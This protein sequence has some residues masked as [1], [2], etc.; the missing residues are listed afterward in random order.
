MAPLRTFKEFKALVEDEWKGT[1]R[2]GVNTNYISIK[3][4]FTNVTKEKLLEE[5]TNTN[6]GFKMT[7]IYVS[8]PCHYIVLNIDMP[9]VTNLDF[10]SRTAQTTIVSWFSA[11]GLRIWDA[12]QLVVYC[13]WYG[14]TSGSWFLFA[15]FSL[16]LMPDT[17]HPLIGKVF[18]AY[19][20]S[21]G[22]YTT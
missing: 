2:D 1:V 14:V 22:K 16:G 8:I 7:Y 4:P 15:L 11:R 18:F 20:L 13:S 17:V 19:S 21:L 10:A 12:E 6:A 9:G 5:M 3:I